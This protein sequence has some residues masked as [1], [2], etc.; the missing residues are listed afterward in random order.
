MKLCLCCSK[1]S[2]DGPFLAQEKPV[3]PAELWGPETLASPSLSPSPA[4]N[5][6]P[7]TTAPWCCSNTPGSFLPQGLCTAVLLSGPLFSSDSQLAPP[8]LSCK[9]LLYIILS[10]KPVPP[11]YNGT[12]WHSNRHPFPALPSAHIVFSPCTSFIYYVYHITALFTDFLCSPV[13]AHGE[14]RDFSL[15][16]S[17]LYLST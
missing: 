9:A 5:S 8:S 16:F 17:Q 15:F 7:T 14:G 3:F 2:K 13:Y 6:S 12:A 1:P 11:I 4:F 10:T